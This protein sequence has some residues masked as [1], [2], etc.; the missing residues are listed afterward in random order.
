MKDI[1]HMNPEI[2]KDIKWFLNFLKLFNGTCS[3]IYQPSNCTDVIEL[4]ACLTGLGGRFN[5]QVYKYQFRNN[6]VP[7]SFSIVHLEMWNV[8]VGTRLWAKQW[9]NKVIVIKCDNEAVVSVVNTGVTR[10]NALAAFERN[11]WLITASHNIKL[12]L[13]HIPGI[14]NECADLLSRWCQIKNNEFKLSCHVSNPVWVQVR[15]IHMFID[16][17]I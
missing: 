1:E 3:Y 16:T 11:I 7:Q 15:S 13:V 12:K 4:D 8:L 17:D 10:D 9:S 6:E 2:I 5:N 14:Q